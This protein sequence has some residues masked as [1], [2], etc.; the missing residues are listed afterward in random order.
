MKSIVESN[1]SNTVRYIKIKLTL[2]RKNLNWNNTCNHFKCT[3]WPKKV[4]HLQIIKKSYKIVL[5]A[6]KPVSEIRYIR[7][8]KV[9]IKHYNSIQ[10]H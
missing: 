3:G 6:L 7:Q 2:L 9:W 1:E 5:K 4:S 10:R 8:I